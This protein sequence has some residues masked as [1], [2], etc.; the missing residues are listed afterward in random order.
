M[1]RRKLLIVDDSDIDR[2]I[3]ANILK[4]DFDITE[5]ENGFRALEFVASRRPDLVLLDISMPVLDGF[6]VLRI[7]SEN[8]VKDI[9]IVVITA[10]ATKA[11]VHRVT[12][13][14]SVTDIISKPFDPIIVRKK[15][16]A[17]FDLKPNPITEASGSIVENECET[18]IA[19][20]Q[21]L[22]RRYLLNQ[23]GDDEHNIHV[24]EVMEILL[25][26]Y[27]SKIRNSGLDNTKIELISNAAYLYN[28]GEMLIPDTVLSG[29]DESTYDPE[30]FRTH[31]TEGASL[32]RLNTA[33]ACRF[34]VEVCAD[35]CMHHH[36]RFGGGGY[37]HG[38][39]GNGIVVYTRMCTLVAE[40]DKL[41]CKRPDFNS[42]QFEFVLNELSYKRG[43]FDPSLVKMLDNCGSFVMDYYRKNVKPAPPE[44]SFR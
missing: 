34:F 7:L 16:S 24:K 6:N 20:L 25:L 36:E 26:E 28:I 39:S 4:D 42:E 12:K 21:A 9:P 18:Y 30:L 14:K 23:G 10:E 1:R 13:Y 35:M 11:N 5:A 3:L 22:Y 32:V 38:I 15:I 37:P 44:R 27:T 8:G 33:P 43:L 31:T 19:N 40:F 17:L 29:G 41:F 2:E